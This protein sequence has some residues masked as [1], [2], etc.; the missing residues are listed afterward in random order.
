MLNANISYGIWQIHRVWWRRVI[1]RYGTIVWLNC[2]VF[3]VKT[4]VWITSSYFLSL[5]RYSVELC[6]LLHLRIW[7]IRLI[8]TQCSG[9]VL[10]LTKLSV[11]FWWWGIRQSCG[12][13]G[14]EEVVWERLIRLYWLERGMLRTE[15]KQINNRHNTNMQ[16]IFQG[17]MKIVIILRQH[18]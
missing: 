3:S 11:T 4:W 2:S 17:L 1:V 5:R 13:H 18:Y 9:T 15:T 12:C 16:M 14:K 6:I 8:S 7:I 10:V